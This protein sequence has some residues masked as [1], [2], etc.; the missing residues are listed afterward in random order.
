MTA[1]N[2]AE[3][4]LALDAD[5]V[6]YSPLIPKPDEVAALLRSGK[7][8]IYPGGLAVPQREAGRAHAGRCGGG[9]RHAA[10]HRHPHPGGISEKFPLVFS[11]M[12][13]GVNFVRAEEFSGPAHLRRSRCGAPRQGIRRHAGTALSGPMQKMLDGGFIQAVKMVVDQVGFEIDPRVRA[14]QEIAVATAPIDSPIG[15][16]EPGPGRSS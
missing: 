14:T 6:I 2:S 11:A 15:V 1:T 4:I 3:E 7:N 13:T 10:R 12:A 9:Q 8:V 16:I 5:A